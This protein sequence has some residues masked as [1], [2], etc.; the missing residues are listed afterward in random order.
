MQGSNEYQSWL[1]SSG[2]VATCENKCLV[3]LQ[4]GVVFDTAKKTKKNAGSLR[5][6]ACSFN[7]RIS[8]CTLARDYLQYIEEN[9]IVCCI[10]E[11]DGCRSREK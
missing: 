11:V 5:L 9:E 8:H 3:L 6:R 7:S 10:F 4:A 1:Q 2:T